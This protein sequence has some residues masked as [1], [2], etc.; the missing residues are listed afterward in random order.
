VCIERSVPTFGVTKRQDRGR[1]D[2]SANLRTST[3][4]GVL[5]LSTGEVTLDEMERVTNPRAQT[6]AGAEVRLP[7]IPADAG[8][9]LGLFEDVPDYGKRNLNHAA[10][11]AESL[12]RDA[13]ENYGWAGPLFVEKL[14]AHIESISPDEPDFSTQ[15][16]IEISRFV[17]SLELPPNADDAVKR[18]ART[19]G[20]IEAAGKLA[21]DFDVVP[22]PSEEMVA[23][24]R[25][26]FLDW[27]K[28]RGGTRS[29][30]SATALIALRD[31]IT[32]NIGRFIP[33]SEAA[34]STASVTAAYRQDGVFYLTSDTWK[35]V[36]KSAPRAKLIEEL[37]RLKFLIRQGSSNR[38]QVAKKFG[39]LYFRLYAISANILQLSD[40]GTLSDDAA[41]D[42]D[43]DPAT[44]TDINTV[45][46][47]R[48]LRGR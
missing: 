17:K 46:A 10:T 2:K 25:K 41:T 11:F 45:R 32:K 34:N 22:I 6:Y 31:Y 40:D 23:G 5:T 24:V 38:D 4:F 8:V 7:S 21:S 29:K 30:T 44:V 39:G 27:V 36:M 1:L 42:G 18:L 13:R 26:C 14:M 20:L 12:Q 37:D 15:L 9:G 47:A 33:A 35:E 19:F 28:S 16:G 43:D 48:S 3:R